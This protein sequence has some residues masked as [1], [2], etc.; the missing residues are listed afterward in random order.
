V[1][2]TLRRSALVAALV[3]SLLTLLVVT[4][5]ARADEATTTTTTTDPTTTAPTST[6]PSTT[7]TTDPATTDTT[8]APDGQPPS[9]QTDDDL[10][11][12][13]FYASQ[14]PFDPAS[15]A[16]LPSE[17]A[18]AQQQQHSIAAQLATADAEL[19]A[20]QQE[21]SAV[22]DD[23]A[24]LQTDQQQAIKDAADAKTLFE[25][26]AV[27]AYMGGRVS[28]SFALLNSS[29]PNDYA[30]RSVM[31]SVVLDR[32]VAAAADYS[33]KRDALSAELQATLDRVDE[34]NQRLDEAKAV[35]FA[36]TL[37]AQA[38]DW[39][40]R[41]ARNNS[42][43]FIPGYVFP[44]AGPVQFGDSFGY[45]RLVGTGQQHW[46]EGCDVMSPMGT[47]LVAAEDGIVTKVGE[48]SLGG[49]SLKI[50][51]TSGYW[52]YY[53]HLSGFAPGLVEGQPIK[54]GTLVGFVGNTG[55]AAGGPTHLHYE[56]HQP[57][58]KVLDSFGLLETA[59]QAR[60]EQLQLGGTS[61]ITPPDFAADPGGIGGFPRYPD[62]R[63]IYTTPEGQA[64]ADAV[65][66]AAGLVFEP[67]PPATPPAPPN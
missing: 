12:R 58:G 16:G 57:D 52:H 35:Q 22:Q 45:P 19:A 56:I 49:L 63:P 1:R 38:A 67:P 31:L 8:A 34:V 37:V 25:Q 46:H 42:H 10:A 4:P 13:G 43:V 32:D 21:A 66:A 65:A 48:N 51:G 33:A 53:A 26:R 64:T 14:G 50:T 24:R 23:L 39:Q 6:D 17:V 9:Q 41:T 47:P 55:D 61:P 20:A 18:R 54:A 3:S 7:S 30:N 5:V 59:W 62:G 15:K 2:Y 36:T 44:V 29:S 40:L 60:Q 11:G 27:A 28:E